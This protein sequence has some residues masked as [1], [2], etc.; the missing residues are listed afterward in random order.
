MVLIMMALIQRTSANSR[1]TALR[2]AEYTCW[3]QHHHRLT[4]RTY[5]QLEIDKP[6][7]TVLGLAAKVPGPPLTPR[8]STHPGPQPAYS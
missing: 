1:L 7:Y 4:R 2:Y 3:I 8:D 6:K 5:I